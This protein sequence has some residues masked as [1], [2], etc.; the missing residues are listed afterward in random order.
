M[1]ILM[2][3]QQ[4]RLLRMIDFPIRQAGL[5]VSDQSDAIL[6]RNVFCRDDYKLVPVDLRVERDF[7]DDSSR[8]LAAN[9]RPVDHARQ[10]HV[11]DVARSAGN[12]VAAFFP[13]Y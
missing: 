8:N 9:R 6:A 10:G 12:F 2:R 4:N 1:R 11:I 5:I 7:L 13:R 3:E